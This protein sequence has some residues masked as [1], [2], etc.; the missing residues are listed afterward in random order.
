MYGGGYTTYGC[1]PVDLMSEEVCGGGGGGIVSGMLYCTITWLPI[2]V[3][4]GE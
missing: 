2:G 1:D 4:S 3:L